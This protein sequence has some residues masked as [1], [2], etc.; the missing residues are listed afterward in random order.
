MHFTRFMVV[1]ELL[2][3]GKPLNRVINY[4]LRDPKSCFLVQKQAESIGSFNIFLS[5]GANDHYVHRIL[6]MGDG[7]SQSSSFYS[8]RSSSVHTEPATVRVKVC[9]LS[10]VCGTATGS[11]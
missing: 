9:S 10:S 7:G 11:A 5:S 6:T 1:L 4:S 2:L 3:K 8:R